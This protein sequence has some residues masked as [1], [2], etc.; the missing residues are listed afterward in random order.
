[1]KLIGIN[2]F[3]RS[4]KD[5]TF[6]TVAA[7]TPD[8]RVERRAFADKLKIMAALAIGFTGPDEH[9]IAEMDKFKED[10]RIE[11]PYEA[12]APFSGLPMPGKRTITGRQYLQWFGAHARDVFGLSFWVDQVA[13]LDDNAFY[14]IWSTIG[15]TGPIVGLPE[16]GC[17]TDVRYPNE[18][19]RVLELDGVVWEVQRPGLES[20]GHSSEEPLPRDLITRVIDNSGDLLHLEREV[21]AA[22]AVL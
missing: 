17:I 20:D 3:K 9:L 1:M 12:N 14:A 11:I 8:Y 19:E 6:R 22:L 5:T 2:G 4:G 16:L 18:A 15:R 7:L 13:P 21:E 10:G